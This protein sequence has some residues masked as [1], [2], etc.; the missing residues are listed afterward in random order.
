MNVSDV[1]LKKI[2]DEPSVYIYWKR[3][4]KLYGGTIEVKEF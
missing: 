2:K 3:L 1:I 4:K